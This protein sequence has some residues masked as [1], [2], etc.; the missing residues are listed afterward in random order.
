M[1]GPILGRSC[2]IGRNVSIGPGAV[3][4]DKTDAHRLHAG[5]DDD[6]NA[7]IF[8]AYDV[9]GL[10]PSE[11]NEDARPAA[12]PRL[13][14]LSRAG[15]IAVSRD[16][17][18]SSPALAA[19]FID[20]ARLQGADVV[21]YGLS[22][23]TCCTTRSP[24]TT[25]TAARR[26]RR[27]TIPASTTAARWSGAE[28]FPLSGEAGIKEMKDMICRRSRLPPRGPRGIG[29]AARHHRPLHRARDVVHRP[30][31]RSSRSTSC[32]TP[33]AAWRALSRRRSSI[34]CPARR[35]GCASRWT[36]RSRITRP[37][38]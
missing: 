29:D 4:G 15:R 18:V 1:H 17:R 27:R 22:A 33:A 14:R 16:M 30:V 25:S 5:P 37:T 2:H 19:A 3:L 32:S 35:R 36:A 31:D 7:D 8:K 28:A 24:P 38:R 34:G 12:R 26:S 10:Y 21:D 23:P 20:G 13:R 6:I 11:I 9:R